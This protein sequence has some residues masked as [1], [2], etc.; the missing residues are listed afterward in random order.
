MGLLWPHFQDNSVLGVIHE[1]MRMKST[2]DRMNKV[3]GLYFHGMFEDIFV[4]G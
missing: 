1:D 2:R 4:Q 3:R